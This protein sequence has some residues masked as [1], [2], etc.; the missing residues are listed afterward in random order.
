[1]VWGMRDMGHP[2]S[3]GTAFHAE[4]M[5]CLMACGGALIVPRNIL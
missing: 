1:M 5:A 2:C 4:A 3:S